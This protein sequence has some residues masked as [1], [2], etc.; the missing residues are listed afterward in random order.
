GKSTLLRIA[1]GLAAPSGGVAD[2]RTDEV[3]FVFQEPTLMPWRTVRRNVELVGELRGLPKA[4][5]RARA[6]ELIERVGL[7]GFADHLPAALSGG[8]QMRAALAQ[9]LVMR[10]RLF[11]FDEPFSALDEPTRQRLADEL[12]AVQAADGF[13]AVFVTHSVSE[14]VY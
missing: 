13:G 7:G 1:A 11:L 2:R 10:P 12:L 8:M 6:A 14:A 9:A 4:R 3:A 5:L